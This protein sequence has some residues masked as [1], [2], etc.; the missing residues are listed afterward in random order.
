MAAGELVSDGIED[1]ATGEPARRAGTDGKGGASAGVGEERGERRR[2]EERGGRRPVEKGGERGCG[3]CGHHGREG[4]GL[5]GA[6][7]GGGT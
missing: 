6:G 7:G 4:R 5:R 2:R 1:G 3:R